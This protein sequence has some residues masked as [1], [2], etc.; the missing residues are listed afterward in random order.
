M[1][2]VEEQSVVDRRLGRID[3][4]EI[5]FL[6]ESGQIVAPSLPNSHTKEGHEPLKGEALLDAWRSWRKN[7]SSLYPMGREEL[8][9]VGVILGS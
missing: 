8:R 4:A 6:M 2:I 9:R 7:A 5:R 1:A 3:L